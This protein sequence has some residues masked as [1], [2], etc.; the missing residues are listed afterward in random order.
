[1]GPLKPQSADKPLVTSLLVPH[2]LLLFLEEL[3]KV[4]NRFLSGKKWEGTCS[5]KLRPSDTD[6]PLRYMRH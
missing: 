3:A 2:E 6:E 4:V 1:M 5:S